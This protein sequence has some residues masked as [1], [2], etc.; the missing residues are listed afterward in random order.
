[1]S[2]REVG[3]VG[4]GQQ[5]IAGLKL[6]GG[7]SVAYERAVVDDGRR[8]AAVVADTHPVTVVQHEPRT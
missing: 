6:D 8:L 5:P 3:E 7:S 2:D 4:L 1:L